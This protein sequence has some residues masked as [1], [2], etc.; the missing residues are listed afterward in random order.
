MMPRD[1]KEGGFTLVELLVAMAM[2]AGVLAAVF[3]IVNL[4]NRSVNVEEEVMDVQQ[5]LRI[6][7]EAVSKDL[8]MSGFMI[9]GTANPV[10]SIGN[11]TGVNGTDVLTLNTASEAGTYARV[12]ASLSTSLIPGTPVTLTVGSGTEAAAF[13][14][15]DIV[16]VLNPA[17]QDQT[18]S[19]S[20]TV[21]GVNTG[22]PSISI[23]P[24]GTGASILFQA[25]DIIAR[26]SASA[27]D[28]FPNT[29]LYCVGPAAG[30]GSGVVT[31]PTGQCLLRIVNGSATADD[32]VA[33]NIDDVQFK[34]L[35]DGSDAESDSVATLSQ[36]RAVRITLDGETVQTA[37]ISGAPR[38]R[39]LTSVVKIRNR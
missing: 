4:Q 22:T 33:S 8:R 25:G 35:I 13:E 36:I 19:M 28:T 16:R 29:I 26:T 24:S 23:D 2:L 18:V 39:E 21:T 7:M 17:S 31:C 12:A 20:F 9:S 32:V 15:G 6:G 27:P 14:A 37:A 5:N 1:V 38:A 3:S 10:G 34:Y 30:C 11:G